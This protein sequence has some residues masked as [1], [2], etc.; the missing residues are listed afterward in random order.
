MVTYEVHREEYLYP[1]I[2]RTI[3]P[4]VSGSQVANVPK[5]QTWSLKVKAGTGWLGF[6]GNTG[7]G[8][9]HSNPNT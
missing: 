3:L 5:L 6:L 9:K 1:S 4:S 7:H 8:H 2:M